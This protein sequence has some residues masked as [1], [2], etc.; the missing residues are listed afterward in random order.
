ML[1]LLKSAVSF[2]HRRTFR[3][4]FRLASKK[5]EVTVISDGGE[6]KIEVGAD[7]YILDALE[8]AGIDQ[9]SSCRAG[10]L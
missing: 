9:M 8:S 4:T 7:E 1:F 6:K 3:P 5:F 2:T 10:S